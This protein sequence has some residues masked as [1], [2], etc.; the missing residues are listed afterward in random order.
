MKSR[1]LIQQSGTESAGLLQKLQT[2][3]FEGLGLTCNLKYGTD[4]GI[5]RGHLSVD[6][7]DSHS[8]LHIAMLLD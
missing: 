4:L 8:V 5:F 3:V 1:G 2:N 7:I 6:S